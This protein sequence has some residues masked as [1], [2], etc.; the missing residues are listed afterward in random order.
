MR[1]DHASG[2]WNVFFEDDVQYG[3]GSVFGKTDDEGKNSYISTDGVS[4]VFQASVLYHEYLHSA[5]NR[6]KDFVPDLFK[7]GSNGSTSRNIGH[8][9]VYMFEWLATKSLRNQGFMQRSDFPPGEFEFSQSGLQLM[10]DKAPLSTIK[11]FLD[12][13]GH[14]R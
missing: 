6:K 2:A 11:R 9:W 4:D 12:K 5:I 13:S 1:V 14:L 10:S 3:G 8:H 7:Q